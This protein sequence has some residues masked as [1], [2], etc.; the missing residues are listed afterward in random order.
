MSSLT[1][2]MGELRNSTADNGV[3]ARVY[4][5]KVENGSRYDNEYQTYQVGYDKKYSVNNGNVF[6][7]YLVSYTD[8]E[9]NYD[10][11]SGENYSV[12]AGMYAT[13]LNNNGH[14]VD[15]LYKVSRLTN[16]FD[17]NGKGNNIHS[18]GEYDTWGMSLSGEYGKRFEITEKFFAE[19]SVQMTFGRLGDETY[20]T[21]SGIEV[22]QDSIYT[23]V[24]RIGTALGYNLSDKGN[25]YVRADVLREFAGDIDSK[26][27]SGNTSVSESEDLSDTWLEFGIGGNYRLRENI[28]MYADVSR[29]GEATVDE[30][31]KANLG[32]RYEF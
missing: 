6:L 5:G 7:G 16:K 21:N 14:Y 8:G 23:A 10:L 19:P 18:S 30:E 3:W 15:V 11:G 24:G 9:T 22:E 13:W 32:F 2:R 12:G 17:V 25:I 29:S 20:T 27:T 26:Y 28:N 4:A 31:W 1:Q